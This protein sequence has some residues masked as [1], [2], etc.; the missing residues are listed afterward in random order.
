MKEVCERLGIIRIITPAYAA[1]VNGLMEGVNRLFL[2]CLKKKCAPDLDESEYQD[3]DPQSIPRN[4]P[5]FFNE[6]VENLNDRIILGTKFT[7]RE[8]LFSLCFA[9]IHLPPNIPLQ[10]PTEDHIDMRM[11][12]AKI[13]RMENLAHHITDS[14][15]RRAHANDSVTP[16]EFNI[17]DLVQVYDTMQEMMHKADQKTLPRWSG[18][19]LVISKGI[20]SYKLARLNGTALDR[21]FHANHLQGFVARPH[22]KLGEL[23][24]SW[25]DECLLGLSGE[26]FEEG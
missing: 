17:G 10:Q 9:P 15:R 1:W 20:N 2:S 3:V 18:P 7:P 13:L 5:D 24:G 12:L 26:V 14:E 4:W 21:N 22:S 23:I 25:K 6:V 11:D 8:I 16:I 19:R